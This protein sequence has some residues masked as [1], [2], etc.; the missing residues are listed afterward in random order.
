MYHLHTH[1]DK[2]WCVN[3]VLVLSYDY[4][5]DE[6]VDLLLFLLRQYDEISTWAYAMRQLMP[7]FTFRRKNTCDS[8]RCDFHDG[9]PVDSGPA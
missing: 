9:E 1:H 8:L 4:M 6:V 5:A 3:D 7:N 2:V